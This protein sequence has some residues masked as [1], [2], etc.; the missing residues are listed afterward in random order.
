MDGGK[1][2]G[3]AGEVEV[4]K[5]ERLAQRREC[6]SWWTNQGRCSANGNVNGISGIS[7]ARAVSIESRARRDDIVGAQSVSQDAEVERPGRTPGEG[8]IWPGQGVLAWNRN[9]AD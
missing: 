7:W 9:Q 5:G 6:P 8:V 4:S 3:G 2:L 1:R